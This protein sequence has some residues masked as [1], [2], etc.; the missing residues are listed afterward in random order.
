MKMA[1]GEAIWESEQPAALS[2]LTIGD[3]SGT[4]EVWSIRIP[5]LM[6]LLVCNNLDCRIT[7]MNELQA[8]FEQQFGPGNYVPP[9]PIVY[10][11]F[12]IMFNAGLLMILLALVGLYFYLR[13]LLKR[14]TWFLR[15]LPWAIVL[16]Y[17]ANT[18]GW[19]MAEVGR[20]PWIVNGLMLTRDG[21]SQVVTSGMVALSL[22]VYTLIY[23][24][25]MAADAY[26]LAKFARRG[27]AI[28]EEAPTLVEAHQVGGGGA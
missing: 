4:R 12:R 24:G 11:S 16:P 21:V 10:W 22:L 13:D 25:L 1:A 17:L 18:A 3:L 14:H 2:L 5:Y 19:I 20:Q 9:I 27:T 26:L 6:S 23:A 8:Q 15:L 7:G 28:K